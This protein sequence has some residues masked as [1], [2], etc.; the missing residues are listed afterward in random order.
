[1]QSLQMLRKQI[2]QRLDAVQKAKQ[3]GVK[4]VGYTLGGFFPEEL[5]I[6]AGMIPLGM[7]AGGSRTN[8]DRSGAYV[9]RWLDTFWRG[10][11]GAALSGSDP[12][13]EALDLLVIPVT[14]NHVRAFADLVVYYGGMN[15]FNFGVPHTKQN[16]SS[17]EYFLNGIKP[18]KEKT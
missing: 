5:L 4:I 8:V 14:D 10:Q 12:Y 1:M 17:L 11:I 13:F 6:A 15:V 9:C 18:F 2:A 3:E 16:I 7:I